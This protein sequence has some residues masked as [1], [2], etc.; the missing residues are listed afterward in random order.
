MHTTTE[1]GRLLTRDALSDIYS[2]DNHA[3]MR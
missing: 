2:R 1:S 3:T